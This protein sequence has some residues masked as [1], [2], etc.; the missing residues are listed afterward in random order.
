MVKGGS[1]DGT[2]I[3]PASSSNC[4]NIWKKDFGFGAC[5]GG[6]CRNG[7]FSLQWA[8]QHPVV[9]GGGKKGSRIGSTRRLPTLTSDFSWL[10]LD[11]GSRHIISS[12]PLHI[13]L[14]VVVLIIFSFFHYRVRP[15]CPV[16]FLTVGLSFY[17]N[18]FQSRY[19]HVFTYCLLGFNRHHPGPPDENPRLL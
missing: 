2:Y 15:T 17:Q 13:A 19:S 16:F 18:P 1:Y 4:W 12:S 8:A 9:V 14:L 10:R 7:G 11:M 5:C 3:Y 6:S